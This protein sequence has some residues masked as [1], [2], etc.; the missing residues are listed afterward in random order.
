MLLFLLI[1]VEKFTYFTPASSHQA[2]KAWQPGSHLDVDST[3]EVVV[4]W[5]SNT[6]FDN[7]KNFHWCLREPPDIGGFAIGGMK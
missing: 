3:T 4:K 6:N 7:S 1:I 2:A 5:S